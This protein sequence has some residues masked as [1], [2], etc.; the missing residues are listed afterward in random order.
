MGVLLVGP[1]PPGTTCPCRGQRGQPRPLWGSLGGD[2]RVA[3]VPPLPTTQIVTQETWRPP[4]WPA[5]VSVRF[6]VTLVALIRAHGLPRLLNKG[7]SY[8]LHTSRS[9]LGACKSKT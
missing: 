1:G 4:P 2:Y 3:A 9:T 8:G 6:L 7:K 5:T